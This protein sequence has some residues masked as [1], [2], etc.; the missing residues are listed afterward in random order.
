MFAATN[1]TITESQKSTFLEGGKRGSCKAASERGT[2]TW[3]GRGVSALFDITKGQ[4]PEPHVSAHT[5]RR[6]RANS[7]QRSEFICTKISV[8]SSKFSKK[9]STFEADNQLEVRRYF[10]SL[11]RS[12]F[13]LLLLSAWPSH[14]RLNF[15]PFYLSFPLFFP[16]ASSGRV[17]ALEVSE[18]F[19]FSRLGQ[20][21]WCKRAPK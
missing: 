20:A 1:H 21:P 7:R 11:S 14:A 19:S 5:L 13:P 15:G 2:G 9:R 10:L 16:T 6:S 12:I 18:M 3:Q 17:T 8:K 4:N